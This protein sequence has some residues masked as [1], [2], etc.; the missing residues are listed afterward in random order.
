M[1]G[2]R[3]ESGQAMVEYAILS[4]AFFT[5]LLFVIDGGRI[6]WNYIT[7]ADAARV[8]ARY[9]V[10]HG[11]KSMAPVGPGSYTAL[12]QNVQSAAVGLTPANLTVTATWTPN[13]DPGSSVTVDV[14][15]LAQ[16]ITGMFWG[17]QTLTLQARSVMVIQN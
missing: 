7:V 14:T 5:M 1:K 9:A 4:V 12:T 15:Y 17:G 2:W 3:R 10:V 6:L 11:S 13:N 8:G 16:P